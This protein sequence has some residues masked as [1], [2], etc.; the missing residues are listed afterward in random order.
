MLPLVWSPSLSAADAGIRPVVWEGYSV[1]C[2]S[3]ASGPRLKVLEAAGIFLVKKI[4]LVWIRFL[5]IYKDEKD[6]IIY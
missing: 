2:R 4:N 1:L 5:I 6:V 3:T